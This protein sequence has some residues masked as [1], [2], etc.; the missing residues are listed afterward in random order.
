[1]IPGPGVRCSGFQGLQ[2]C[3]GFCVRDF[4]ALLSSRQSEHKSVGQG[5][6]KISFKESRV[7]FVLWGSAHRVQGSGLAVQ[8]LGL[9]RLG[10][11]GL[12][13]ML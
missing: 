5:I 12:G 10:S 6:D 4:R 3:H 13:F 2:R 8:L 7:R 1:M 11:F 9:Q